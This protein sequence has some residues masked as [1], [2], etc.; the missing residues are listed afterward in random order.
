MNGEK[1]RLLYNGGG[2]EEEEE[3]EEVIVQI[4]GSR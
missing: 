3:E 1:V 4:N 2:E